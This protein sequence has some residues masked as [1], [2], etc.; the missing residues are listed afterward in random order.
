MRMEKM[1]IAFQLGAPTLEPGVLNLAAAH[2]W[3]VTRPALAGARVV[4]ADGTEVRDGRVPAREGDVRLF[5]QLPGGRRGDAAVGH[6]VTLRTA[7]GFTESGLKRTKI[8]WK[9]DLTPAPSAFAGGTSDVVSTA[10]LDG[11]DL[12]EPFALLFEG[13][14]VIEKAGRYTLGIGSDDGSVLYLDGKRILE[15]DGAHGYYERTVTV[16]LQPGVYPLQL[17]YFDAGGAQR[18]SLFWT[19]PGGQ[20]ETI[21]NLRHR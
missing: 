17:T 9:G 5:F 8:A 2:E 14:L 15:N 7:T 12:K 19:P 6:A 11:L 1:G 3:K 18:V 20:R 10:T 21:A 16:D 4:L 13:G